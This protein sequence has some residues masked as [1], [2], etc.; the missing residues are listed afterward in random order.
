MD[1]PTSKQNQIHTLKTKGKQQ[2][3]HTRNQHLF[4]HP[5]PDT[6][7]QLLTNFTWL[8]LPA[9]SVHSAKAPFRDSAGFLRSPSFW[10]RNLVVDS[11]LTVLTLLTHPPPPPVLLPLQHLL[12]CLLHAFPTERLHSLYLHRSLPLLILANCLDLTTKSGSH[13]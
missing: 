9:S 2:E 13:C 6:L 5:L 3:A 7:P 8:L 12:S 4:L 10:I 1:P 11:C